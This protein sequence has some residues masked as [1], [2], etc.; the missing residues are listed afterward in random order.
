ML[1]LEVND[2][3]KRIPDVSNTT[4][5]GSCAD[6]TVIATLARAARRANMVRG[7]CG[8]REIRPTGHIPAA[9]EPFIGQREANRRLS[10][11]HLKGRIL[12]ARLGR[13]IAQHA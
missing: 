9:S 11:A 7:L 13:V 8:R 3:S 6:T 5:T 10:S 4:G 1:Q 2:L 12:K